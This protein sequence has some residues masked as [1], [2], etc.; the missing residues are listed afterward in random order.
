[1]RNKCATKNLCFPILTLRSQLGICYAQ[2]DRRYQYQAEELLCGVLDNLQLSSN[3][4]EKLVCRRLYTTFRL[5]VFY[6]ENGKL[7]KAKELSTKWLEFYSQCQQTLSDCE[8][9]MK[10]IQLVKPGP[11]CDIAGSSE[12][13]NYN[14]NY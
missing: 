10:D 14:L 7:S 6:K 4:D 12:R 2:M 8:T 1:M 11:I 5:S 3:V 9:E 13:F